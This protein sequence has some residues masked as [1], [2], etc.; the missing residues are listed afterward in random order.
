MRRRGKKELVAKEKEREVSGG[1]V[2]QTH[3]ERVLAEGCKAYQEAK[4]DT[5]RAEDPSPLTLSVR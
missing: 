2:T 3:G 4:L 1:D 5:H